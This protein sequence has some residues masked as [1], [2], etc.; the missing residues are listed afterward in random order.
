MVGMNHLMLLILLIAMVAA[1][2]V[3]GESYD[4]SWLGMF[5][6]LFSFILLCSVYVGICLISLWWQPSLPV[7]KTGKCKRH[8][9]YTLLRVIPEG[10]VYRCA[11]GN[12]YLGTRTAKGG[13]LLLEYGHDGSTRAYMHCSRFGRWKK[14]N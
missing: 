12:E 7:C 6:G 9:D 13:K 11:C 5:L 8:K 4:H 3:I 14:T 10:G 2:T 1:G